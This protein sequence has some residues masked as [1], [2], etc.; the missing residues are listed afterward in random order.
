MDCLFC[1]IASGDI[2][3][4]VVFSDERVVAFRDI[5]PVAP[6]HLVVIPR[7]H[8]ADAAALAAA[9]ATLSAYLLAVMSQL[10][11]EHCPAGFRMVFNTGADG[12][13]T[14]GHVHGHVIG[15]RSMT[16]PPG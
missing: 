1:S 14:V 13:Q 3:A 6:T 9:D 10:G 15:G 8:H 4:D 16:W 2:P 7:E 5:A 12:G 11:S